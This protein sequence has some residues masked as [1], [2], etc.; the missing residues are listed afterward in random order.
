MRTIRET[1]WDPI[2]EVSVELYLKNKCVVGVCGRVD[3]LG[4]L[5]VP[6]EAIKDLGGIP[7]SVRIGEGKPQ[8]VASDDIRYDGDGIK[9]TLLLLREDQDS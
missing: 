3:T 1:C 7:Y 4:R 6:P 2:S 5:Y 8:Y 9:W